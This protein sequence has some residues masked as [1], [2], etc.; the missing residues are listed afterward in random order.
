MTW[1]V[2]CPAHQTRD[3]HVLSLIEYQHIQNCTHIIVACSF[4]AYFRG[5]LYTYI[6][7]LGYIYGIWWVA[8]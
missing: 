6:L 3:S 2:W 1:L 8:I 7:V 5:I 4:S